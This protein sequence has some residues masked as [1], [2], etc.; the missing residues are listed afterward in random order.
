MNEAFLMAH[1]RVSTRSTHQSGTG[2]SDCQVD[3]C[4]FRER[5]ED[6]PISL[7]MSG[8]I[9][10]NCGVRH[11]ANPRD[12]ELSVSVSWITVAVIVMSAMSM[13]AEFIR[14]VIGKVTER[15]AGTRKLYR[16]TQSHD[17]Q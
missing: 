4:F 8:E 10:S 1:F 14:F 11:S 3:E 12:G 7:K 16:A 9:D 17:R 5:T 13:I 15:T 2:I 6:K